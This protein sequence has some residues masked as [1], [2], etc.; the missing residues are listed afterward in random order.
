MRIRCEHI[1][2]LQSLQKLSLQKLSSYIMSWIVSITLTPFQLRLVNRILF[3]ICS[4]GHCLYVFDPV[5]SY[6]WLEDGERSLSFR[7]NT[8]LDVAGYILRET[9]ILWCYTSCNGPLEIG[10]AWTERVGQGE[11]GGCNWRVQAAWLLLGS[12]LETP[13]LALGGPL[14]F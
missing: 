5:C 3:F 7:F 2:D 9:V 12:A 11:V 1:W 8:F 14:L 4:L 13:W 6:I 10:C